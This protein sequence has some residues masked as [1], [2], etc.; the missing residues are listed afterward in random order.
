MLLRPV[1]ALNLLLVDKGNNN[2]IKDPYSQTVVADNLTKAS[3]MMKRFS[4]CHL[5]NVESKLKTC[6][7]RE[8]W[9]ICVLFLHRQ[10]CW[11][12]CINTAIGY[13]SIFNQIK[14]GILNTWNTSENCISL[15]WLIMDGVLFWTFNVEQTVLMVALKSSEAT[16]SK[17][18]S[19]S[20][21]AEASHEASRSRG[22]ALLH[23]MANNY[24]K[25]SEL[26]EMYINFIVTGNLDPVC[27][28]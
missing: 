6:E 18:Q 3:S 13:Q 8:T 15:F 7:M 24:R 1:D 2:V 26:F 27:F 12:K 25:W 10:Q 14:V 21:R 16:S 11:K 9:I 23:L 17:C 4:W 20:T 28:V 19:P 22:A 5:R